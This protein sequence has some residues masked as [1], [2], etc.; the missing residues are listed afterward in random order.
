MSDFSHQNFS[1]SEL[2]PQGRTRLR[3]ADT[4]HVKQRACCN[5]NTSAWG[6]ANRFPGASRYFLTIIAGFASKSPL[7]SALVFPL[8]SVLTLTLATT[9]L[10]TGTAQAATAN[11][12]GG[13][14]TWDTTATNWD[15][16]ATVGNPVS[17]NNAT[18]DIAIFGGTAGTVTLGTAITADSLQFDTAGYVVTGSTVTL[19]GSSTI[20]A[21]Q[22][23]EIQSV[24]AGTAGLTKAGT[25]T[26]TATG[27]NTYT[28]NTTV[29]AG[30]LQIGGAGTLGG[31][32]YSGN[33]AVANGATFQY[34]SSATNTAAIYRGDISGDGTFIKDGSNSTLRLQGTTTVANLEINQGTLR[35]QNVNGAGGTGTTIFLGDTSGSN[36]ATLWYTANA[37]T[38]PTKAGIVVRAGSSGT[39]S[40]ANTTTGGALIEN[41]AITLNDDLTINDSALMTLGGVISGSG[42]LTKI[43]DGTTTL[44]G[45]NTYTGA[46]DVQAGTL[47]A[48]STTAFG[49]NSA[50]TVDS[51]AVLELDGN[52]NSIGSLAG[53]GTVENASATAATLTTGGDNT[54]TTF[55]GVLQDGTGGGALSLTKTGSGTQ[56]L[57]GA[58]TYRALLPSIPR[59]RCNWSATTSPGAIPSP[60]TARCS[61]SSAQVAAVPPCPTSRV[62]PARWT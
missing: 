52:N 29:S 14:G 25:G 24:I 30:T 17:W 37:A 31:G 47:R 10:F 49:N 3:R 21:D 41:T 51:G 60:A 26:L 32:D 42:G 59:E 28:G 9:L 53:A 12:D 39:K 54:S 1:T 13:T 18:P 61:L 23:A 58:N 8:T 7:K 5:S 44:S 2:R 57:S 16:A 38:A 11:A 50:T 33:I 40:I 34:S 22:D 27:V 35:S 55:S 62:S 45:N 19:S 43:G 4:K 15:D 56:T 6:C 46:N 20:T 48:G 36:F